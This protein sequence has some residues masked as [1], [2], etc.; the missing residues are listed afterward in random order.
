MT[1]STGV[2]LICVLVGILAT[3]FAILYIAKDD[4]AR[5]VTVGGVPENT[6]IGDISSTAHEASRNGTNNVRKPAR[7]PD[8]TYNQDDEEPN[9]SKVELT[10][11]ERID[12]W[13][14]GD[15]RDY[16]SI[17]DAWETGERTRAKTSRH[18]WEEKYANQGRDILLAAAAELKVQLRRERK[19]ALAFAFDQGLYKVKP[20]DANGLPPMFISK[21]NEPH[22]A[23]RQVVL[24][25]GVIEYREARIP[26]D[27]YGEYY[28]RFDEL[29][30]LNGQAPEY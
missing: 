13:L 6:G 14:E 7:Q 12:Q 9:T 29:E 4:V 22:G 15:R 5:G 28:Y 19:E 17:K 24:D 18:I 11:R 25:G 21:S 10:A 2:R 26:F 3:T 27:F 8:S 1:P 20:A 23:M 16:A 30:W